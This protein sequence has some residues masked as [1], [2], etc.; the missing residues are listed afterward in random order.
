M[1]RSNM[2]VEEI[3]KIAQIGAGVMGH[4]IAQ[5]A[6]MAGYDVM[7]MD[8]SR[9]ALDQAMKLINTSLSKLVE[10]KKI[11]EEQKNAV[12]G[13]I[14]PTTDLKEAVKDADYVIEAVFESLPLKKEIFMAMDDAAPEHAILASNTS[15][16]PAT[17]LG[18]VTS[19]PEKVIDMH[20]FNPAQLMR[21]IEIMPGEKTSEETINVTVELSKKLGK[22]PI[23]LK[24][25][26]WGYVTSRMA[27]S[28]LY[29][30]AWDLQRGVAEPKEIDAAVRYKLGFPMG[31]FE[32]AD[33]T[34]IDIGR[35]MDDIVE[36]LSETHP[37]YVEGPVVR[38]PPIIKEY[39]EKG[40]HGM[41]SGR[42]FYEYPGPG[43]YKRVEIPEELKEKYDP[44]RFIST[45]VNVAA[46]LLRT[47]VSTRDDIDTMMKLGLGYPKG[48]FQFADEPGVSKIVETLKDAKEKYGHDWYEPD[49]LLVEMAEAGKKFY[50]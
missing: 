6:A 21:L 13:K 11:T 50:E 16:I 25:D 2:K 45:L 18:D 33:L 1:Q 34:G 46:Y 47:E 27:I 41:K 22:T 49:P 19:R 43:V 23:V 29:E 17:L 39:I 4:G 35:E 3:K 14:K 28:F 20:W 38:G 5:V 9:A 10:K 40:W 42:G 48:I 7:L 8:V 36:E 44:T 15:T 31:P 26:V 30:G 37:K 24:K 12:L 32:L